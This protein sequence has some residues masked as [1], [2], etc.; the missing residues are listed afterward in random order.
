[1]TSFSVKTFSTKND[2]TPSHNLQV[3]QGLSP[4]SLVDGC[5]SIMKKSVF[6]VLVASSLFVMG[7]SP[8]PNDDT[9]QSLTNADNNN[10]QVDSQSLNHSVAV[11]EATP[12]PTA[13][14]QSIKAQTVN[15]QTV[16]TQKVETQATA[17]ATS[18][19][20]AQ[21]KN[22]LDTDSVSTEQSK[23][24]AL[25][26]AKQAIQSEDG[27]DSLQTGN[28]DKGIN[29]EVN[30]V[31]AQPD[32]M[33]ELDSLNEKTPALTSSLM[34]D[35]S[36]KAVAT[37][38]DNKTEAN[39]PKNAQQTASKTAYRSP[40]PADKA[41]LL[42][43]KVMAG[44]PEATVQ[45]ALDTLYYGDAKAAVQF[46]QV[47]GMPD[48][49]VQLQNTQ[50]AFKQTVEQVTIHKTHYNTDKTEA[51]LDGEIKIKGMERSTPMIYKLKKIDGQWKILG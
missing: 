24:A 38:A 22:T 11:A 18:T 6:A 44:S 36:K 50:N 49:D 14:D 41:S 3:S 45:N 2:I 30:P 1:M 35:T 42:T 8:S 51:T 12:E 48:F 39:K 17:D 5:V 47:E 33:I 9:S 16:N 7:C 37:V 21:I 15:S 10:T 23:Q 28:A 27:T 13:I 40:K 4:Y 43:N 34:A 19:E 26:Q 31:L 25:L 20:T 32:S 29:E 46:Y